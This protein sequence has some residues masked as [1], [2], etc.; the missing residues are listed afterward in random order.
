[1]KRR[2]LLIGLLPIGLLA[3]YVGRLAG[4]PMER[5]DEEYLARLR[6]EGLL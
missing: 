5:V 6:E 3:Y 2:W 1:M 4:W